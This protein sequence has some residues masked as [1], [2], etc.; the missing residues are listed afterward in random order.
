MLNYLLT[1]VQLG[2]GEEREATD[3]RRHR[4]GIESMQEA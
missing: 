3:S 2:Y 4:Y 1:D